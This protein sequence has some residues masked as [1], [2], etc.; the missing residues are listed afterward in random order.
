MDLSMRHRGIITVF[1]G[2]IPQS[3]ELRSIV[4]GWI[5]ID[6]ILVLTWW[7][8]D[9]VTRA[10]YL[11]L[12]LIDRK[13]PETYRVVYDDLPKTPLECS[14]DSR[15]KILSKNCSAYLGRNCNLENQD[16]GKLRGK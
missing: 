1:V 13:T 9:H 10:W 6:E 14:Q 12:I 5:L 4:F 7:R 16:S 11:A 2:F 3:L 8:R 15:F